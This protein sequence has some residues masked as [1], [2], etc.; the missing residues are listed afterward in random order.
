MPLV[1]ASAFLAAE[2]ALVCSTT[3]QR[4]TICPGNLPPSGPGVHGPL[5]IGSY[6]TV[7]GLA[8]GIYDT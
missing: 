8:D 7:P 3:A 4:I 6:V 5:A 1:V 2:P